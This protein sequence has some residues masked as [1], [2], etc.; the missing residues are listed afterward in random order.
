MEIKSELFEDKYF[1]PL[2][3]NIINISQIDDKQNFRVRLIEYINDTAD[4]ND[5]LFFYE[6]LEFVR[7]LKPDTDSIAY[8]TPDKLIY[9]NAPGKEVGEQMRV[10]DFIYCHECLHQLWDTFAVG[11]K[12]KKEGI[13]Y[14]HYLLNIASDCV[15]NDYLKVLRKKTMF[16][17]GVSPEYLENKYG[18]TYDRTKD[19]QYSLYKK[20]LEKKKEIEND[21]QMQDMMNDAGHNDKGEQQRNGQGGQD[22]QNGQDG[23]AQQGNDSGNGN[24]EQKD[25]T[26]DDAQKS[27]DA[28]KKSAAIAQKEANSPNADKEAQTHADK[29]KDAAKRAQDAADKAKECADKG[30]K[31]GENKAAKEAAAAAEEAKREATRAGGIDIEDM[32][33]NSD[34]KSS[35]NGDDQGDADSDKQG[36]G[37]G[38]DNTEIEVNLDE[39]RKRASQ[40]ID[41]YK[42]KISGPLGEYLKQ[43]KEAKNLT[44][45][46]IKLKVQSGGSQSWNQT[47]ESMINTF[48]KQKVANKKRLMVSSYRRVKRGSGPV[49]SGQ[50]ILPGKIIKKDALSLN[51]AFYIDRSGSMEQNIK[52]VFDACYKIA[53]ALKK[54][55]GKEQ[56]IKNIDF[57]VFAFNLEMTEIKFGN[58]ISAS[59]G[60][61]D[62]DKILNFIDKNTDN[63]L[64]NI[65]ITDAGFSVN[66]TEVDKL[67]KTIDGMCVF[68]SNVEEPTIKKI[69]K[70]SS[71]LFYVLADNNFDID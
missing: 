10:W 46:N 63:Y 33:N 52:R 2:K 69:A 5:D 67:L 30:D 56:L 45:G 41:K 43:C 19:N 4:N 27:A 51:A 24:N 22:G 64:I 58:R 38:T 59:G 18:V 7:F 71:K 62:F 12:I 49:E 23:Q 65:I 16:E 32:K 1:A 8:T 70:D 6:M 17:K 54:R 26:A 53:E 39:I 55:F 66:K 34:N 20:L 28:A 44:E 13:E 9:L 68:V 37:K 3:N 48:V 57:K 25:L 40:V 21:Q 50:P 36:N 14:N 29:A 35:N 31:K 61:M 47:M 60:T 15:I 42:N 11:D